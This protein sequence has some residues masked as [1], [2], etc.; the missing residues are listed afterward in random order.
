MGI[1]LG[2]GHLPWVPMASLHQIN[3]SDGG[4]PKLPVETALVHERGL[5]GDRQEDTEHHGSP[6]QALCL[7]SLEVIERLQAEGHPIAPGSVGEN[8]TI[9]G[10]DWNGVVPGKVY[11]IGDSARFEVTSYTTPCSKNAQW[12]LDGQFG[13]ILQTRHPGESRVY[14]KVLSGGEIRVGDQVRLVE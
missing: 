5:A 1:G 11:Q 8:L 9:A 12:F 13:R 4:V 7:Y 2:W 10:V 14:A 6:E 3:I